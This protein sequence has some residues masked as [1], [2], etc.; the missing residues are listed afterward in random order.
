MTPCPKLSTKQTEEK[1]QIGTG[2]VVE[3]REKSIFKTADI[4]GEAATTLLHK[5]WEEKKPYLNFAFGVNAAL[6]T[7]LYLKC[8]LLIDCGKFPNIHDLRLLFDR[9]TSETRRTLEKAHAKEVKND[10]ALTIM[11]KH[12]V[13]TELDTLLEKGKNVFVLF[14]YPYEPARTDDV[15]FGLS[16]LANCARR[17]I[18][19]LHPEW[20]GVESTSLDH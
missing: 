18:L 1:A 14:R 4:F 6:A 12:G 17:H 10:P 13:N 16:A 15:F 3:S 11:R 7:E 20:I 5:A 2:E 8:L 19:T 9:L